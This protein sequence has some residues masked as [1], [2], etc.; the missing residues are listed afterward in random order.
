MIYLKTPDVI[1]R[2]MP[3]HRAVLEIVLSRTEGVTESRL[4]EILKREY[5][6]EPSRPELYHVLMKLELQGLIYVEP[7]GREYL[8]KA[9]SIAREQSINSS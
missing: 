8:I 9:T 2:K 4:I 7:V 5:D 6:Y 1:W 3:L